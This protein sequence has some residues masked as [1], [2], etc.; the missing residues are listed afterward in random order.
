VL[1][2]PQKYLITELMKSKNIENVLSKAVKRNKEGVQLYFP[3]CKLHFC[4][5][6]VENERNNLN[7]RLSFKCFNY[8]YICRY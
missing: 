5:F 1:H 8:Y 4:L 3:V 7:Y 6:K 2:P